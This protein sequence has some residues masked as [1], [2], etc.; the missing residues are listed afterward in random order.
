VDGIQ[1]R[2]D[3]KIEDATPDSESP[4]KTLEDVKEGDS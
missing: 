1:D 2:A 3:D 4:E